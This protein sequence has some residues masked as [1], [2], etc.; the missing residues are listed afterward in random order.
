MGQSCPDEL[1]IWPTDGHRLVLSADANQDHVIESSADLTAKSSAESS[2]IVRGVEA[3]RIARIQE[4]T[5]FGMGCPASPE[6]SCANMPPNSP[7][8]LIAA[9]ESIGGMTCT[10]VCLHRKTLEDIEL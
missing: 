7:L 3:E 2:D 8:Q 1:H 9:A 6:Y 10:T 5:A 4:C